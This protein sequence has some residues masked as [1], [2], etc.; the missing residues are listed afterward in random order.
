[1]LTVRVLY[2]DNQ[3]PRLAMC[4]KGNWVDVRVVNIDGKQWF[5]HN[6]SFY[7]PY[8][9]GEYLLLRLGFALQMPVGY[10]AHLVPRSSTFKTYGFI[11][12]NGMGVIDWTY[13]GPDDEWCM[14]V[15]TTSDGV[16]MKYDRVGQFRLMPAM[17]EIKIQEVDEFNEPNRGGFGSTGVR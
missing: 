6:N 1:M 12:T 10:E 11:Q 5:E 15:F 8:F 14:P 4:S 17:G 16:I 3:M 9:A 2:K 7:I 13:R